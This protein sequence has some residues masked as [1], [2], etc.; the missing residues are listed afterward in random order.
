MGILGVILFVTSSIVG[1]LLIEEYSVV[2]QLISESYAIDTEYGVLLRMLGYIPS[3]LLIALFCFLSAPYFDTS[4]WT[5]VGLY[6]M[7]I[8][9]GMATIIVSIFPCDSGCNRE[10]IDPSTS[11]L[12]HNITGL[13]TYLAVPF[14]IMAIGVG[15]KNS[16]YNRFSIQSIVLA[17]L[18]FAGVLMLLTNPNSAYIGLYQRTVELTILL[19]I[20]LC[21][22]TIKHA[23]QAVV[24]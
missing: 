2:K 5:K 10:L 3:G 19:W 15:L 7:G 1:G 8:F 23:S 6:G 16:A 12:I 22:V 17:V 11:Q 21:A 14:C 24:V 4:R 9:Y 18:S 13:F 20:V